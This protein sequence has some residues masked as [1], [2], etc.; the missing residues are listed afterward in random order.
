MQ[1]CGM[2]MPLQGYMLVHSKFP[3]W[4]R[5]AY[6]VPFHTYAFRSLMFNDFSGHSVMVN[7]LNA[8]LDLEMGMNVLKSYEIEDT[9]IRHNLI[10]LFCY[11]LV[12][13]CGF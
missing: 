6:H 2:L 3:N 7:S 8:D 1:I 9:N 4:L 13:F 5:W 10:V 11:G 12:S